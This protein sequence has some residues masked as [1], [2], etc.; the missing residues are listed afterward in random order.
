MFDPLLEPDK[1]QRVRMMEKREK[2]T[3]VAR[4]R[5]RMTKEEREE[6]ELRLEAEKLAFL[7]RRDGLAGVA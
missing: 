5:D 2:W 4:I 1:K 3:S 6:E 7:A